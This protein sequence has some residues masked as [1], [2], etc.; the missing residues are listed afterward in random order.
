MQSRRFSVRVR[1]CRGSGCDSW[2]V[3]RNQSKDATEQ[4]EGYCY[5]TED[6]VG[7]RE[8]E[9]SQITLPSRVNTL[10][11]YLSLSWRIEGRRFASFVSFVVKK[12]LKTNQTTLQSNRG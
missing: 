12:A 4:S 7:K 6:I 1:V 3:C 10:I 9:H 8:L 2:N 11:P 5:D